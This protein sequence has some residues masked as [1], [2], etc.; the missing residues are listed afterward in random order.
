MKW[1]ANGRRDFAAFFQL[2]AIVGV[3][4]SSPQNQ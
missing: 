4:Y 3:A 2:L 1:I